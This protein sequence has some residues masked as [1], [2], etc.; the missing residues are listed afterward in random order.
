MFHKQLHHI[1][2]LRILTNSLHARCSPAITHVTGLGCTHLPISTAWGAK[3]SAVRRARS[4][5]GSLGY[6]GLPGVAIVLAARAPTTNFVGLATGSNKGVLQFRQ[7][8]HGIAQLRSG[9]HV[10]NVSVAGGVVT[11]FLDGQRV[12]QDAV[13]LPQKV[14]LAFTAATSTFTDW[15]QVANVAISAAS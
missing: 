11:V 7:T 15:H 5:G 12:L 8:V 14:V 9:I 3:S 10:V 13:S 4:A 6:G 2:L 1:G